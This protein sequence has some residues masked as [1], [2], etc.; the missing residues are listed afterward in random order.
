MSWSERI[1][2][3]FGDVDKIF[4]GHA[5]DCERAAAMLAEA[6]Q[7][8]V[9]WAD[10]LHEIEKWLASVGADKAHTAKQMKRVR[11]LRSYLK[12]D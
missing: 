2:G 9:G 8:G 12:Y 4:A 6:N 11:D 7:E 5:N 10:Y 3:C 1:P